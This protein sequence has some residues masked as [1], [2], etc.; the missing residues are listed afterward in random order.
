MV[1]STT[2]KAN[3]KYLDPIPSKFFA[4]FSKFGNANLAGRKKKKKRPRKYYEV[5]IVVPLQMK[6]GMQT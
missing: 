5:S 6:L 3:S 4:N 1:V 2:N